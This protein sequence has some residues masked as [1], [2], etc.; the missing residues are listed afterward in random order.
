MRSTLPAEHGA[1]DMAK[2]RLYLGVKLILGHANGG[3]GAG[4]EVVQYSGV[5]KKNVAL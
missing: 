4:L 5:S 3:V 2:G 1:C